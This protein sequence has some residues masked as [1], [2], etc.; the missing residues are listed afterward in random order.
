MSV[1]P[2]I[3]KHGTIL[4]SSWKL[5]RKLTSELGLMF[6]EEVDWR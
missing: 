3:L 2:E 5:S 1:F 6:V 4:P